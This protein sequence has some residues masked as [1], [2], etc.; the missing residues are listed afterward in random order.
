MA[1]TPIKTP[2]V[3]KKM[4]PNYIWDISTTSKTI[5]LTFDD[6][7]TPKI[8][9][10]TLKTLK[11]FNAKATFFCIGKNI[12][13]NPEIFQN[14]LKEGHSIGNHTQ[15]H[16]KGWKT[17][18]KKYLKNIE[19]AKISIEKT[20]HYSDKTVNLFRPP[21]G[22]IT[23]KQGKKLMALGYKIIMWDVLSFDW[24]K[25]VS[26]KTCLENVISKTREGSIVVFHDSIKA[27]KNM[28]Y[29]LP[30]V[31]EHFSNLNYSFSAI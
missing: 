12:E 27:S 5:Y 6:G 10:W 28:K 13:E 14:I 29:T 31:L 20:N 3:A 2:V 16:M 30:K 22:Q 19:E 21:Y 17:S 1:L 8:T 15:N 23:P 9:D 4:F 25:N 7:P 24:D 26:K 11:D 18:S